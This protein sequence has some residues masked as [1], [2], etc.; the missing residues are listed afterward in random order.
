MSI[1]AL[2]IGLLGVIAIII[3]W[4]VSYL[5]SNLASGP[6][7]ATVF[8]ESRPLVEFTL[9]DHEQQPFDQTRFEGRWSLVFFGFTNCPGVCPTTLAKLSQVVSA[10]DKPPAVIFIS[11][12]PQRDDP[13]T[14]AQYVRSFD[15]QLVG[16]SGDPEEL[17]KLSAAFFVSYSLSGSG[18]G[19][20]V[21]HS[22]TVF[23][24]N[25]A[26]RLSALFSAPLDAQ[27]LAAD[28]RKII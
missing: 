24:V 8:D 26:G 15:D 1:R 22:S 28:L 25:P 9:M 21:D 12:D 16:V 4:W 2:L 27:Q 7:A 10:M 6:V 14:L 13:A 17:D 18:E 19:Y 5:W 20:M 3:G 11:V 23:L